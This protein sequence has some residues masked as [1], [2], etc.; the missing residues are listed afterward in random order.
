MTTTEDDTK[1]ISGEDETEW[2]TYFKEFEKYAAKYPKVALLY[3]IGDFYEIF[4]VDNEEEQVGNMRQICKATGLHMSKVGIKKNP[5]LSDNNRNKNPLKGGFQKNGFFDF[6]PQLVEHGFT[7]VVISQTGNEYIAADGRKKKERAL[8]RIISPGTFVDVVSDNDSSFSVSIFIENHTTPSKKETIRKCGQGWHDCVYSIGMSA[9]DWSTNCEDGV[10]HEAFDKT[11]DKMYALNELY[12]FLHSHAPKEVSI[13]YKFSFEFDSPDRE[14]DSSNRILSEESWK[15]Y[16]TRELELTKFRVARFEKVEANYVST[17]YQEQVFRKVFPKTG[18]LNPIDWLHLAQKKHAR[19]SFVQLLQ[20]AYERDSRILTA[21]NRPQL[22]NTGKHLLISNDAMYQLHILRPRSS[23]ETEEPGL[24]DIMDKTR[25]AMGKRM[26][27]HDILNPIVNSKEL[28]KRY[29]LVEELLPKKFHRELQLKFLSKIGDLERMYRHISL[30]ILRPCNLSILHSSHGIIKKMFTW[31]QNIE[32]ESSS[33][34]HLSMLIKDFPKEAITSMKKFMQTCSSLYQ[35]EKLSECTY[36]ERIEDSFLRPG[37][38]EYIE[39]DALQEKIEESR[40]A[41]QRLVKVIHNLIDPNAKNPCVS[42]KKLPSKSNKESFALNCSKPRFKLIDH[43]LTALKKSNNVFRYSSVKTFQRKARYKQDEEEQE[44]EPEPQDKDPLLSS[45]EVKYLK[46]ITN[47]NRTRLKTNVQF[48]ST[49]VNESKDV[50]SELLAQMNEKMQMIYTQHLKHYAEEFVPHLQKLAAFVA[51][52]DVLSSHA[53]IADEYSYCKPIVAPKEEASDNAFIRGVNI[54]HPI[55][56]RILTET[57]YVPNDIYIGERCEESNDSAAEESNNED[58]NGIMLFGVNNCGKSTYLRAVGLCVVMAQIGSFV[59]AESFLY[60]PF[61]HIL[62]RLSGHDNMYK[63]QGSF[64]VEI[65]ELRDIAYRCTKHSLVLGDELCHGTEQWSGNGIVTGGIVYLSQKT[66]FILSSH[67]HDT[68]KQPEILELNNVKTLHLQVDRDPQTNRLTYKRKLQDGPGDPSYGIEVARAIDLPEE[69]LDI[70]ETVR[71]RYL[72]QTQAI[73]PMK[74]SRYNA[75]VHMINCY[76]CGKPSEE[77][78]H[79]KE[80]HLADED[81]KI[82]HFHK[83]HPANLS[84]LCKKCHLRVTRGE[85]TMEP[86]VLTSE[87]IRIPI[88]DHTLDSKQKKISFG[89]K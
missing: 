44:G 50:M 65:A 29:N 61:Q 67:L 45:V 33:S 54:R 28:K 1:I 8:D 59:P 84:P 30:G 83:N 76:I 72:D 40:E 24:I 18:M 21:L 15:A 60:A 46:S 82:E 68:P 36:I 89:K 80:Q 78:N 22:W 35:F 86:P 79:I 27:K 12:R 57:L 56:E 10:I 51:R 77:T 14:R 52:L 55:V 47:I 71:K 26:L 20:F 31:I 19:V 4:G 70:A 66:N 5:D 11:C 3:Q 2:I 69:I 58:V 48:Q 49:I 6:V 34:E 42:V 39:I 62:T 32:G 85:L 64:E 7:V 23:S 16:I 17:R 25:T 38:P 43:Y 74:T 63:G 9:L 88:I 41:V 75:A 73:V 37:N 81:G 13:S 53:Q 87:G